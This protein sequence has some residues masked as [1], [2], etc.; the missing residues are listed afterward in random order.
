[1]RFSE[2]VIRKIKT[3]PTVLHPLDANAYADWSVNYVKANRHAYLV[4]MNTRSLYTVV[5]PAE[6]IVTPVTLEARLAAYMKD[7]LE[8]DGFVF[9]Y[10][11]FIDR[12]GESATCSKLLNPASVALLN[13]ISELVQYH[14][15]EE[16][17]SLTETAEI[18]N[19]GP[20]SALG[21]KTPRQTFQTMGL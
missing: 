18:I 14:L 2:S 9:F 17:R 20:L 16:D 6:G 19:A 5:A 8:H 3:R 12:D 21:H 10:R 15:T 11:R 4:G 13:D 7:Y 1:M